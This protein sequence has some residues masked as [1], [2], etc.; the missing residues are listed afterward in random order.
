MESNRQRAAKTI[1]NIVEKQFEEHE[2][3]VGDELAKMEVSDIRVKLVLN[4][5]EIMAKIGAC[6]AP[7][8]SNR[9][10]LG[11]GR[12]HQYIHSTMMQF[13]HYNKRFEDQYT[14]KIENGKY[15][16]KYNRNYFIGTLVRR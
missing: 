5:L 16:S 13:G 10:N 15:I 8:N 11:S 14:Y 7:Q 4:S 3:I 2:T 9:G 6:F 1:Q 12:K